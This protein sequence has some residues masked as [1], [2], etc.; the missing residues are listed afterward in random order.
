MTFYDYY[1]HAK[2]LEKVDRIINY[3][4]AHPPPF[5]PTT[6]IGYQLSN[7]NRSILIVSIKY[8]R[9]NQSMSAIDW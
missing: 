6:C 2:A 9:I 4:G 1:G 7:T 5:L 3:H 8:H